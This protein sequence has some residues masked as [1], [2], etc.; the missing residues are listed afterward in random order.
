MQTKKRTYK[1]Y[2]R[3]WVYGFNVDKESIDFNLNEVKKAGIGGVEL[4]FL[5]PIEMEGN[6]EFLSPIFLEN[7]NYFIKKAD[8]LDLDVDLTLGSGWPL[9]APFI[10]KSMAPDILIPYQ[11]DIFGPTKYSFDYTN[12][13]S[14][15][16]VRVILAEVVEGRIKADTMKDVTDH[17]EA[18]YIGVWPWGE[19][20]ENL[21]VKEGIYR[22]FVFVSNEYRQRVGKATT[23]MDGYVMDH[24]RADVIDL[25]LEHLGDALLDNID[26]EKVRAVFS[27]SIE[28]TA[29]N[30]TKFLP[31][32]F[33]KRR[34]YELDQYLP[35]LWQDVGEV[36]PY[37]RADYYRTYGELTVENFFEKIAKWSE[38]R[39]VLFRSQAHGTWGDA[40]DAYAASHIPEGETFG[41]GDSLGVN[42]NH[43]RIAVSGGMMRRAEI[44]S[45]E[46]YT[47]LRKP[48]F[49]VTLEMM[50]R[51]TDVCF[52]DGINHIVN[53]GYSFYKGSSYENLFYAS[54]V[55]SPH[56]T[57]WEYYP[58]L[59]KY[60]ENVS[61]YMQNSKI[62]TRIGMLTPTSD[63]WAKNIMAELHMTLKI[64]QHI[65]TEL[66]DAIARAGYWFA[67]VNDRLI[68]EQEDVLRL[69]DN[70]L[71][72]L[73]IPSVT[74]INLKTLEKIQELSKSTKIV[75]LDQMPT[76]C[77]TFD[78]YEEKNSEIEKITKNL[79]HNSN[80][81][82]MQKCEVEEKLPNIIKPDLVMNE[83]NAVGYIIRE[84]NKGERYIFIS[85]ITEK[86]RQIEIRIDDM[87]KFRIYD[88]MEDANRKDYTF[89]QGKIQLVLRENESII[90]VE[91]EHCSNHAV[92]EKAILDEVLEL[93]EWSLTIGDKLVHSGKLKLWEDMSGYE[94]YSGKGSYTTEF[95]WND[96]QEAIL[97]LE[98][99]HEVCEVIVNGERTG[100]IWKKPYEIKIGKYLKAGKNHIKLIVS[101][102]LFNG[103][104]AFEAKMPQGA[105]S[106]H[107]PHFN[108]VIEQQRKDKVDTFRERDENLG[109]QKSGL[110][111]SAKICFRK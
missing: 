91:D 111:K 46:T 102:L 1:P 40:I 67:F 97:V 87:K 82:L 15:K 60:I 9:G 23:N 74:Y 71:E 106:E 99:V 19:K 105:V 53:H 84:N 54:S 107:S 70:Q 62:K 7:L 48:R 34:G 86:S 11:Q 108:L 109:P 89:E 58:V 33:A 93:E 25:Y 31:E 3:M 68:Q 83:K 13:L 10:T 16:I 104:L 52:V 28:L 8:E 63:I 94:Y 42:I 38:E 72:V 39:G 37:I 65:T 22:L 100:I 64:E 57:W 29:S 4:Q 59:S 79:S 75:F 24:C 49:L 14:G 20:I 80:V 44:V 51:A 5:Y 66:A 26:S 21:E 50:K 12:V 76:R 27:D 32:E 41:N 69:E 61:E 101:N 17:I 55:V 81:F 30:W 103:A 78:N 6:Q 36:T 92:K 85:N 45:N 43:H 90:I 77:D 98:S 18:T 110:S 88:P 2:T 73:I 96:S 56:N 35:A 47:W 95:E